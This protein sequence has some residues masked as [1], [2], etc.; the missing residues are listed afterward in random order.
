MPRDT[1]GYTIKDTWDVLGMRATASDD[2]I[3]DGAV[4]PRPV[5]RPRGAGRV[6]RRRPLRPR[7]LRVGADRLRQRLLRPRAA[8]CSI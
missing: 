2:T 7:R 6:R 8:R 1:E 3:L 4:R 5:H